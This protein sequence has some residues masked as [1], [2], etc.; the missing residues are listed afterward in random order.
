MASLW[1]IL[2][3]SNLRY[4]SLLGATLADSG[5]GPPAG[6]DGWVRTGNPPS[7]LPLAGDGNCLAWS[8]NMNLFFG[9]TAKLGTDWSASSALGGV[10]DVGTSL[11]NG[12]YRV[13]CIE[14]AAL[15][16][17]GFESGDTAMWSSTVG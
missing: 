12:S 15:F 13:W 10:W 1:E 8:T 11:C 4:D 6:L 7:G 9:S 2:D 5:Q 17:D 16:A 3:P 14:D